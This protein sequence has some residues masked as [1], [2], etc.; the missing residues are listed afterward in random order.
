MYYIGPHVS[1]AKDISLAPERAKELGATGFALFTKNQK[2]W[3]AKP[4]EEESIKAFEE[5]MKRLAFPRES[6]LPHAGY[7]I[8]PATGKDDLREKS[9]L[10]MLDEMER[11]KLLDLKALNIHPGAYVEGERED[12]IK[13]TVL[14]IDQVLERTESVMIALE[15]TAGAGTVLGDKLEELEKMMALSKHPERIGITIDTMHLFGAGYDVKGNVGKVMDEVFSRFGEEKLIGMHLNDSKVPL[16]SHKDRHESLG[17]GLIGIEP[18]LHLMHD[19]RLEGKP[20]VLE[21]PNEEKWAEEI[22]ILL[23][24]GKK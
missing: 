13:R 7:L 5:N 15:N 3:K 8:N 2:I 23:D 19:E 12:G 16:S 18:F 10:L 21:T 11:A 24:E 4:L 6:V 20:L 22:R 17:E 1:I 14:F 9:F